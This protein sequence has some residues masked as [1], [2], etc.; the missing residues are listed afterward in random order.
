MEL[1][2]ICFQKHLLNTKHVQAF[3]WGAGH[4]DNPW[5]EEQ[6]QKNKSV[7]KYNILGGQKRSTY[8]NSAESW[9]IRGN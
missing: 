6:G 9:I 5:I 8:P 1:L 2:L 4:R 3:Y 7:I